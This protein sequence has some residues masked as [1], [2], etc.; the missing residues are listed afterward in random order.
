MSHL[1]KEFAGSTRDVFHRNVEEDEP[2]C[3][4]DNWQSSVMYLNQE[5]ELAGLPSIYN[6]ELCQS[7]L[8][9]IALINVTWALLQTQKGWF[10]QC[11]PAL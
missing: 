2:F 5:L 1:E 7:Q 6:V 8:D 4:Q 9:V 3:S 11:Q 10:I